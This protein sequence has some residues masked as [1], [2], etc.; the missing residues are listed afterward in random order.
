[1]PIIA[2]GA[3]L[4]ALS[5][6]V[7]CAAPGA[8]QVPPEL[9]SPP[10]PAESQNPVL[11]VRALYRYHFAH[12][13]AFTQAALRRRAR[14]L[15]PGLLRLCRAYFARPEPADEV[16]PIDGDPFTDSQDTP[17]SYSVGAA[18]RSAGATLVPVALSWSGGDRKVV[19]VVVVRRGTSWL[20]DD[21]RYDSGDTFRGL[22][23]A[24]P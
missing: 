13:M 5:V 7:L 10:P 17:N 6:L 24:K 18:T 4:G 19:S 12:D 21:I 14:W 16:P 23:T 22:L 9:P 11:V 2:R 1:M 20:I 3:I 8:A 15:S